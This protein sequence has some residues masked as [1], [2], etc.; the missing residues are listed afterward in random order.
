MWIRVHV[1][2]HIFVCRS[3]GFKSS[4][5]SEKH[6]NT[7]THTHHF[8]FASFCIIFSFRLAF[9]GFENMFHPRDTFLPARNSWV[10][11]L[12]SSLVPRLLR[13]VGLGTRRS[14]VILRIAVSLCVESVCR[15]CWAQT[16][17]DY[18]Y[19]FL[20]WMTKKSEVR[21]RQQRVCC[22]E[23]GVCLTMLHR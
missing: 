6:G 23:V 14:E 11:A 9:F 22:E 5:Q 10:F 4:K 21:R 7:H 20:N 19:Y 15:L 1:T 8:N 12:S 13:A 2:I 3:N 16:A 18:Q 17:N